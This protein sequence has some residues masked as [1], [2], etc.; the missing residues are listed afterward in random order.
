M[1]L[2]LTFTAFFSFSFFVY[3]FIYF[4]LRISIFVQLYSFFNQKC[5]LHF[6]NCFSCMPRCVKNIDLMNFLYHNTNSQITK[7]K[8]LGSEFC[9]LQVCIIAV[10]F[11]RCVAVND[12]F[13]EVRWSIFLN[14]LFS[15]FTYL[16]ID[17]IDFRV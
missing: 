1:V 13:Q 17:L 15:I 9:Q 14:D 5:H 16:L 10:S 7:A 6:I 8:C 4:F 2:S 11:F 3:L 12:L